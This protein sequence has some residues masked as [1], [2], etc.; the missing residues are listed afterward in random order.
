MTTALEVY[1]GLLKE[2][3]KWE[4]PSFSIK[5]FNYFVNSAMLEYTNNNFAEFD[6]KGKTLDDIRVLIPDPLPITLT[7]GRGTLPTDYLHLLSCD[8]VV[9]YTLDHTFRRK[10][11]LVTYKGID[12]YV[13]DR[14][15][16]RDKNSY[17]RDSPTKPQYQITGNNLTIKIGTVNYAVA[18]SAKIEYVKKPPAIY[19]DPRVR[20]NISFDVN[21][22]PSVFPSEVNREI[23]KLCRRIILENFESNRYQTQMAE[24]AQR[25][26]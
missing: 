16:Y 6:V 13:S 18:D 2:L 8:I 22:I 20:Q 23:V 21:S 15:G 3:D 24:Q 14:S 11:D 10:D 1:Q 7:N 5:D 17:L 4:S 25:K 9:K 26:E 19:L 12:R